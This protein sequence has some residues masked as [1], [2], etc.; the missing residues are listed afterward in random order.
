M[1][2]FMSPALA[3]VSKTVVLAFSAFVL[4][5]VPANAHAHLSAAEPRV[6][7]TIASAPHE[8]KLSFTQDLESVFS[9]V[10]VTDAEGARVDEGEPQISGRVMRVGLK[11]LQPGA[12]T[13][14]WRALSV[15]TH[16]T[17]GTFMFRVGK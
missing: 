2:R 9:S 1:A 6:D 7:S 5:A 8:V 4:G 11:A 17:D 13:V 12:Y 15:D 16:K 10:E 14:H 3:L